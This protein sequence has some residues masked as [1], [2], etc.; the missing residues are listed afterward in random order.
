MDYSIL[1]YS[2]NYI[3][4][5][6]LHYLKVGKSFFLAQ[7]LV[8]FFFYLLFYLARGRKAGKIVRINNKV[9]KTTENCSSERLNPN[10]RFYVT[11]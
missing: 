10:K 5:Y 1:G 11:L 6:G 8:N 3:F 4:S 9:N 7:L 2:V